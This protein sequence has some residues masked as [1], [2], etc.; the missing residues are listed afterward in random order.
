MALESC[1][2]DLDMNEQVNHQEGV[3]VSLQR[4]PRIA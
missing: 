1:F 4:D 3:L 2:V